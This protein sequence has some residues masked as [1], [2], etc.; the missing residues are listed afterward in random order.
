MRQVGPSARMWLLAAVVLVG[1]GSFASVSAARATA[2]EV[3]R[4][5]SDEAADS[6]AQIAAALKLA[7]QH[8][9]DL[10]GASGAF[11]S[12]DPHASVAD[13]VGWTSA[14]RIFEHYPELQR[15]GE[16]VVVPASGL[17]AFAARSVI[18][19]SGPLTATGTFAVSPPG[20]RP[21]YCLSTVS[22][23]R[24]GIPAA[25]AGT[26]YCDGPQR[27]GYLRSEHTGIGSYLPL[28][29]G[30]GK[31]LALGTP[32]YRGGVVP[33]TTT[34]RLAAFMGWMGVELRPAA[35][36]DAALRG[37]SG[38]SLVLNYGR[39]SSAVTFRAGSE[40]AGVPSYRI[41]VG[42]GW[43][44]L[45]ISPAIG[46]GMLVGADALTLLVSGIIVS[47][48]FGLLIYVLGTSRSR[49]MKVLRQRTAEIH[50]RANHDSLT[51]LP[52][53]ALILD[54]LGQ[55]VARSEREQ[56]SVAALF[57]DIDNFKEFN[58]TLSHSAGDQLLV[59]I[60]ARLSAALRRQDSVGR[61]GGDEFV[62][63][64]DGDA[65]PEPGGT[66]AAA[67][68]IVGA[69]GHPFVIS[70]SVT[71]LNVTASIG[72]AEGIGPTAERLLKN[73]D[74]ALHGAKAAGKHRTVRFS[75]TM[76]TELDDRRTLALDLREALEGGQFFLLYQP[77]V[78][79]V[80]GAICGVEVLLRWRH[81]ERGIV[82]P[83]EFVPMLESSGLI[84]PVGNWVLETACRQSALWCGSHPDFA[85]AVNVSG[86]QLEDDQIVDDVR[87][88][89]SATGF[90][91]A[92]LTLE[93]TESA[94]MR[95]VASTAARLSQLKMLGVSLA[96][97]DF[98]TGYSSLAYLRQFPIDVLKIDRSF[99]AAMGETPESNGLVHLLARL[100]RLLGLQTIA[101]GVETTGQLATLRSE[102]VDIGQG[103]LFAKPLDVGA[104]DRLVMEQPRYFEA[105]TIVS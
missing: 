72:I 2:Q 22:R 59:A 15:I 93:L 69:L 61:L 13:F 92:K 5:S 105:E 63:L 51:G 33:P 58:D 97:D 79:L 29:S 40:R 38:D 53:R 101:E 54:R 18:D 90:D 34:E 55:M 48:M 86:V 80:S 43:T 67:Q 26:D 41:P 37:H 87:A 91:P 11:M 81:P 28:G 31:M 21:Y 44:V 39:S 62:V 50:Y 68:R 60:G 17:A 64:L 46:S 76:Q 4:S 56:S 7:I 49:T 27:A 8:E 98:G 42:S 23:T 66:D 83:D 30:A 12:S 19:P 88:A 45:V 57:I 99:V 89:L 25:P 10:V 73:A 77:T 3:Q 24:R 35:I 32:L 52:N 85:V 6:A 9:E 75:P 103:F 47:L 1:L 78:S 14:A 74:I 95:D 20:A 65:E 96:V 82:Q 70:D 100:G 36:L 16:L 84:V 71:P 102:Q 104:L 94:L